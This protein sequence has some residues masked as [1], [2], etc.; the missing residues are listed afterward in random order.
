M[1]EEVTRREEEIEQLEETVTEDTWKTD[2]RG[3]LIITKRIFK[4]KIEVLQIIHNVGS[5]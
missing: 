3:S 2:P 5:K 1:N 4:L